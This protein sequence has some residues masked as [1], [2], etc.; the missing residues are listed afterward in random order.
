MTVVLS[1]IFFFF[2]SCRVMALELPDIEETLISSIE[3]VRVKQI[4]GDTVLIE[5]SGRGI[6]YPVRAFDSGCSA[7][8]R[9]QGT[10]LSDGG[11]AKNQH[12]RDLELSYDYPLARR[13]NFLA[14]EDGSLTMRITGGKPLRV[15]KF[16][17][18]EYSD[19]LSVYLE[20]VPVPDP[21]RA[22]KKSTPV[23]EVTLPIDSKVTL[24]MREV[25]PADA[26]RTLASLA[27]VNLA[28][29]GPVQ[30]GKLTFSFNDVSFS[31]VFEY[32][33]SATGLSYAMKGNTLL[34]GSLENVA[35]AAGDYE[36]LA[37]PIAYADLDRAA[38]LVAAVVQRMK[39]PL[40]DERTRTLYIT[41]TAA[42]H[43]KVRTFLREIDRPGRQIMLEARLIDVNESARHEIETMISSVHSGWLIAHGASGGLIGHLS[44]RVRDAGLPGG[45]QM[46]KDIDAG[47][48]AIE[49]KQKVKV[50]AAPSLV[51]LDGHKAVIK[52]TRNYLYQSSVDS[53]GNA[54]FTEQETGPWLEITPQ[55]G[56]DGFITMKLRI[57]SGEIIGFRRSGVSESPETSKREVDT[58]VRVRDGELFVI[59]GLYSD[60]RN[61][62]VRK[63]PVLSHIPLIGELF[64]SKSKSSFS[65]ELA[66]IVVP[67][68]LDTD[69]ETCETWSAGIGCGHQ[70]PCPGE[71][72]T[73]INTYP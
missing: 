2:S 37:Y 4:G 44:G 48:R 13:I 65:S 14:G 69:R 33:L 12:T 7:V 18:M 66:F 15:K 27:G 29:D 36:T 47:L 62:S 3:A 35:S 31:E 61:N 38:S 25:S 55:I 72:W 49:S 43:E 11:G 17:G 51:T 8:L 46:I 53:E 52:L 73:S 5:L 28:V 32:L 68:I 63:V 19:L 22:V 54:R 57:S 23:S 64:K 6:G 42:Q 24:S 9:W 10:T 20:T 1:I 71:L 59:G 60:S 30:S 34:L 56:R 41:A 16:S 39:A 26:F 40:A 58:Y 45:G 70:A 67:H 50:L 21:V